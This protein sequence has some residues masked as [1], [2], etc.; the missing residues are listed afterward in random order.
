M[1]GG[2][3][4]FVDD[5]ESRTISTMALSGGRMTWIVAVPWAPE[6]LPR[7]ANKRYITVDGGVDEAK[8]GHTGKLSRCPVPPCS[9]LP[10]LQSCSAL[11]GAAG[12]PGEGLY[13]E[14]D[15][16]QHLTCANSARRVRLL[17]S[18]PQVLRRR[19][20]WGTLH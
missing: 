14:H 1:Q 12:K 10:A 19:S 15:H 16:R 18:M 2:M 17:G 20:V 3:L 13:P 11:W 7:L 8:S 4:S 5:T 6:E 9:P